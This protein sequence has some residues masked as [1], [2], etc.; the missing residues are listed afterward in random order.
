MPR[1]AWTVLDDSRRVYLD[2]EAGCVTHSATSQELWDGKCYNPFCKK[3]QAGDLSWKDA[4]KAS[5][6]DSMRTQITEDE[7]CSSSGWNFRFAP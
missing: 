7:L 2:D 4:Y 6:L 3:V 5:A 1:V